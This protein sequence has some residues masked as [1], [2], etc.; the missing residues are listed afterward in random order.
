MDQYRIILGNKG[1]SQKHAPWYMRRAEEFMRY[2]GYTDPQ[3]LDR[4]VVEK[5]LAE[6][7]RQNRLEDWQFRQVADAM[8][9]LTEDLAKHAWAK[10]IDWPFWRGTRKE[11]DK[12]HAT[13]YREGRESKADFSRYNMDEHAAAP[14]GMKDTLERIRNVIRRKNY[15]VRTE[16]TYLLWCGKF[17]RFHSCGSPKALSADSV[18]AYLAY[19]ALKR[20]VAVST[21][22][23]ALNSVMFMFKQVFGME[24]GDFSDFTRSKRPQRLPV[25]LGVEEVRKV[26]AQMQGA[27]ALMSGLMYGAGMRL[28][29]CLRLRVQDVDFGYGQIVVRDGKGGK[30][31]VVPLPERYVPHLKKQ[32]ELVEK[33]HL[34]D[35]NAGFGEVFVPSSVAN[36]QPKA[37]WELKWQYLFPASKLSVDRRSGKTRRHHAHESSVQKAVKRAAAEAGIM[38]RVTCHTLRHS[39]ATHLLEGGAD[40]RTV[41]ELLGH[42]D[43][44]TTMIYTHVM[45]RPGLSVR[46]PADLL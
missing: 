43:V 35:L 24:L 25:V 5:Y 40:I 7:G 38:K 15:S 30:D 26:L 32:V 19:L 3:G 14:E 2:A 9:I 29:E 16:Q 44:S 27:Q 20:H 37:A 12:D 11:V 21:Q 36:K 39:F 13:L 31:R 10:E 34:K 1:V 4:E 41:Q 17:L 22:K 23:Q 8:R 18:K 6:L 46:S 45:N 42:A 33:L 28:M